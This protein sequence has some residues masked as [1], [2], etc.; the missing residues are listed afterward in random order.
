MR[1][2]LL[3]LCALTLGLVSKARADDPRPIKVLIIT[4]DN[5]PAH[6][7][8]GTTQA[9]RDLLSAQGLAN[10]DATS[11]PADDLTDANLAKYDV[12]LLNYR[13]T[14]QG[15][16]K[17]K[18]SDANRAA[19]LKAVKD[20]K[21]LVVVHWASASFVK[22]QWEEFEKA[23]AGGWRT[24][25]FHGPPHEYTVKATDVSHPISEGLPEFKHVKDELYQN[26]MLTPGSTV[27]ATAYSDP[28]L[29]KGTGKDEA[30]IWV[31]TYGKGR[32][33]NDV[34]GHDVSA[35]NDPGA[36]AWL[37]RAVEWAA[38]GRVTPTGKVATTPKG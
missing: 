18:W 27:L 4:G 26:S 37:K 32:V 29:P 30:M 25:G 14:D 8:K 2:T 28:K 16:P 34:M 20:G 36:Q 9:L 35:I 10:V 11:T 7:W 38:T 15:G 23:V 24:Q 5:I 12:L 6:D 31:N 22:P 17:T 19:F 1:R 33:V 13:D 3:S 21:G